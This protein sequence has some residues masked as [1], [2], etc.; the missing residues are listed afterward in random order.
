MVSAMHLT[1]WQPADV[2]GSIAE[3]DLWNA[4]LSYSNQL[5]RVGEA[6]WQLE[7][8]ASEPP[9]PSATAVLIVP[10]TGPR[11]VA[12]IT[13]F[14]FRAMFDADLDMNDV[15]TL[16]T[17][18]RDGL[19]DG[20]VSLLWSVLPDDRLGAYRISEVGPVDV[21]APKSGAMFRWLSVRI[22]GL[23]PDPVTFTIGFPTIDSVHA[24]TGG[25]LARNAVASEL[26]RSLTTPAYHTLGS[27]RTTLDAVDR[28][29][30]GDV[31][32]LSARPADLTAIRI[33]HASCLFRFTED[34]WIC[35]GWETAGHDNVAAA[36][37]EDTSAMT[38]QTTA[39]PAAPNRPGLLNVLIDFD[40]GRFDVPLADLD[41]WQ[42]GMQVMLDPP[43]SADGIEV[44]LRVNG[45]IIGTGDLIR[46][47]DRIAI[48]L[49]RLV[50]RN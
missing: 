33:R 25:I 37:T 22:D 17:A 41:T 11:L 24:L 12:V 36:K 39:S 32:V 27:L 28:L 7:F 5:L 18:L 38:E 30:P 29:E 23:A 21:I 13:S 2:V 19:H 20:I 16:P 48:R 4:I 45:Q 10:Q 1:P 42:P 14:P 47:D 49:T 15:A 8:S 46:I 6:D 50:F 44:T 43:A 26:R 31:V 34:A 3:S 40:L 9:R 35:T